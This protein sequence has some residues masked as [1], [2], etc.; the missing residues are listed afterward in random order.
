MM[1]HTYGWMS[2][3]AGGGMWIWAVD[4]EDAHAKLRFYRQTVQCNGFNDYPIY[5]SGLFS[6]FTHTIKMV[7]FSVKFILGIHA[8]Q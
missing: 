3:W 6:K 8:G 1:N 2:G 7:Q 5:K 4:N